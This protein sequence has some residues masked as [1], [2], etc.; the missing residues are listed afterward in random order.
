[1]YEDKKLN[2]TCGRY[3]THIRWANKPSS[4][5]G[6]TPIT[7]CLNDEAVHVGVIEDDKITPPTSNLI[8]TRSLPDLNPDGYK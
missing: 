6:D 8:N 7:T 5:D 4:S 2:L 3:S 1:M